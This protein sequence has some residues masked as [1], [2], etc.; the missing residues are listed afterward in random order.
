MGHFQRRAIAFDRDQ[1][2]AA[3]GQVRRVEAQ[4]APIQRPVGQN[5]GTTGVL[6]QE[7]LGTFAGGWFAVDAV[8]AATQCDVRDLRGIRRPG[9]G[10]DRFARLARRDLSATAAGEI[11]DP[12]IV[13]L[14]RQVG[15]DDGHARGIR[16]EDRLVV[17]RALTN[18]RDDRP[19]LVEE[20]ELT[21]ILAGSTC[22]GSGAVLGLGFGAIVGGDLRRLGERQCRRQEDRRGQ[23]SHTAPDEPS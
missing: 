9:R 4:H 17:T 14:L 21:R 22:D 12:E 8:A 19:L 3:A 6:I 5:D 7:F 15:R 10:L 13:G 11:H 18:G 2:Q 20:R 16:R 1:V 23:D